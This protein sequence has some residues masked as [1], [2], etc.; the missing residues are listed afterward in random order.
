MN[1]RE[2][3]LTYNPKGARKAVFLDVDDTLYDHLAPLRGALVDVLGLPASFPFDKAYHLFRYYSDS[4]SDREGLSAAPDKE[5]MEV[6]R[7]RRFM[8]MLADL[9]VHVDEGQAGR[10]QASYLKGQFAITPFEGATRLIRELGE[11]GFLVG[12]IT[13]GPGSHQRRKID[14]LAVKTW[15]PETHMFISGDIGYSKPDPRLFAHVNGQTGTSAENSVYIGDSWRNDV[16]GSV[17]A[18]WTSI[19]FNHRGAEPE[20]AHKPHYIVSSYA[21]ISGILL[22]QRRPGGKNAYKRFSGL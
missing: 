12:V 21:E 2:L 14:A 13:N 15:I 17:D 10:L 20:S 4:L 11:A 18:G 8:L 5:K 9:G 6:M 1:E 22:G 19:W 16:V 7:K 3:T